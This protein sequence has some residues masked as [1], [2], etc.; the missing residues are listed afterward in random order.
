VNL[1]RNVDPARD[2]VKGAWQVD[3]SLVSVPETGARIEFQYSPPDEYDYQVTFSRNTG[4]DAAVFV[5]TEAG[6][7]FMFFVGGYANTIAAF[8]DID[9]IGGDKNQTSIKRS[10]WLVNGKKYTC[11]LKVR[12]DSVAAYIDGKFITQYRGDFSNVST[13]WAMRHETLV[14]VGSQNQQTIFYS[15]RIIKLS[16]RGSELPDTT[17]TKDQT[18][19]QLSGGS[20]SILSD[21]GLILTNRHVVH[22]AKT[23]VVLIG[24]QRIPAEIV[25]EDDEYDLALVRIKTDKK[26]PFLKLA[27]ADHPNAGADALVM[28]FPLLFE[29]GTDL[30]VTRGIVTA[31]EHEVE[32]GADTMIDAKINHGNS[33]GPILDRY[34]NIMAVVCLKTAGGGTDE[35]YGIGISAGHVRK[36]LAKHKITL[37]PGDAKTPLTSEEIAK[38]SKSAVVCILGAQ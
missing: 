20:G 6:Y 4:N 25:A 3:S 11:V 23:L 32:N 17:A 26:L 36:F 1:L 22:D 35:S 33:G 30:K 10:S 29:M 18:Y 38:A 19:S 24:D 21:D 8:E 7:Q 12:R 13:G 28:G 5:A 37:T 27:A 2:S 34:G 9:H 14:G 16:G 15:A 31:A